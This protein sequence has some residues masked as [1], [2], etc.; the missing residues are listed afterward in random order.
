MYSQA[1]RRALEC[2]I[3][4]INGSSVLWQFQY[5]SYNLTKSP[6]LISIEHIPN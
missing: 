2:Y 6:L 4:K 1:I 5:L 3:G